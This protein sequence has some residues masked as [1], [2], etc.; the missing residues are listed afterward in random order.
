LQ[1]RQVTWVDPQ[2]SH[3]SEGVVASDAWPGRCG[4]GGAGEGWSGTIPTYGRTWWRARPRR[5]AVPR[6]LVIAVA[7]CLPKSLRPSHT[8][9]CRVPTRLS[10]AS[11]GGRIASHCI[12][13]RS[14]GLAHTA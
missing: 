4:S 1:L 12:A 6:E 13:T 11:F 10:L 3:C 2:T 9:R 5:S 7:V 8:L 14:S